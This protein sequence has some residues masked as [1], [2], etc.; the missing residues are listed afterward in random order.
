V[1]RTNR[2]KKTRPG[3]PSVGRPSLVTRSRLKE[4]STR[5]A[6]YCSLKKGTELSLAAP[7]YCEPGD[8]DLDENHGREILG[9]GRCNATVLPEKVSGSQSGQS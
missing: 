9:V 7:V 5:G 6:E 3:N 2:K 1:S 8:L 4:L